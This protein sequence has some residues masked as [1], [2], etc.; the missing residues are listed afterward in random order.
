MQRK[1]LAF[2]SVVWFVCCY[3]VLLG[4]VLH[5]PPEWIRWVATHCLGASQL[6]PV[7]ALFLAR[8]LGA[9]LIFFGIGMGLAA[10]NPNKNRALLTLGAILVLFRSVQRIAQADTLQETL[11]L[12]AATNWTTI[13]ILWLFAVVLLLFRLQ[14]YRE[15]QTECQADHRESQ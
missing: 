12:S 4:I 9:Y 15:R 6:P 8:M 2:R 10:W 5:C 3:H 7:S 14:L 11:G 13:I 1:Y